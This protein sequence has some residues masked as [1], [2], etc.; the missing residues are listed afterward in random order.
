MTRRAVLSVATG[1]WYVEGQLRLWYSLED[2][3][4]N[5]TRL[6]WK[7][8]YPPGS[9][10]H[11]EA[12]YAFKVYAFQRARELGFDQA[13]WLDA[14]CWALRDLGELWAQVDADGYYLEPD[15]HTTGEWISDHALGLLGLNRDEAMG[16]PL[17]E[18]KC[19]GLDLQDETA[20][21]FL[22]VWRRLADEGGFHGPW[23]NDG[24]ASAD[25]RCR[26]HRHDI[27]C[28]SPLAWSF[29]L[30]LQP[31]KRIGF[32]A[33]GEPGPEIVCLAQGM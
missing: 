16:I 15:G 32:P 4:E 18:G 8:R 30:H 31:F 20:V 17:I 1:G 33:N 13:I 26:G 6:F 21:A 10:S 12:P 7:D 11:E 19:V 29:G 24:S 25:P 27:A 22:D 14:S 9:P 5:A 3:G 28:A 23:T 2:R